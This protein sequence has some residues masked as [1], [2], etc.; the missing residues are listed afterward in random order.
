MPTNRIRSEQDMQDVR[1]CCITG[2]R[3]TSRI[4]TDVIQS[5][6]RFI[7]VCSKRKSDEYWDDIIITTPK[8]INRTPELGIEL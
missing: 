1:K 6:S 3:W 2:E 4:T 7:N 8:E 5:M